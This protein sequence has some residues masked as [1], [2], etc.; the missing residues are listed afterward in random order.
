MGLDMYAF[1]SRTPA[2]RKFSD[3]THRGTMRDERIYYWH[4]RRELDDWMTRL[5][6][7]SGFEGSFNGDIIELDAKDLQALAIDTIS[8]EL[9]HDD[10]EAYASHI[11]SDLNFIAQAR[12][13]IAR[14]Y[15]VYYT[16]SW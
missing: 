6:F 7:E 11:L 8:T 13:W 14:G 4:D 5:A 15:Y 16:N 10:D 3:R 9:Y 2:E 12:Y 1:R